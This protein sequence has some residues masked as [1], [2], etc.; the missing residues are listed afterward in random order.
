[1][2]SLLSMERQPHIHRLTTDIGVAVNHNLC[3]PT[4]RPDALW[5]SMLSVEAETTTE[6]PSA[7]QILDRVRSVAI[8]THDVVFDRDR[9]GQLPIIMSIVPIRKF[10]DARPFESCQRHGR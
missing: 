8:V 7:R 10:V 4:A 1:M 9:S 3:N 2:I 5:R 6:S